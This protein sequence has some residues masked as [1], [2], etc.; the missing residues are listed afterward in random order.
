MKKA[1]VLFT[2]NLIALTSFS[3]DKKI[4]NEEY[5]G[6][7]KNVAVQHFL[8]YKIPASITMAQAILESGSGNS[9]LAQK[10]NNHFGIKCHDWTG[11]K[12]YIDDDQKD[13]CFRVY[14]SP[15]ASYQDHSV[16]LTSKKR[17]A[18][19]FELPKTDYKSWAKGLKDAGYATNPKYPNLLIDLIER[20]HLEDLDKINSLQDAP[21]NEELVAESNNKKS[22]VQ[23]TS[24]LNTALVH[25][26]QVKY[27]VAQK[28]DTYYQIAERFG[29]ALWEL[30]KYNDLD[31]HQDCL[32]E[33]DVVYVQPKRNKGLSDFIVLDKEMTLNQVAQQEAIKVKK[34]M[35]KND[36]QNPNSLLAK[37]TKLKL[38]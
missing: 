37:G 8:I 36:L 12:I 28:G 30:Y 31:A 10:G 27:V 16:F 15:E 23:L 11:E 26:N 20:L 29:M 22:K 13:D 21:K 4:S 24:R 18:N 6:K 35:R 34:I 38:R 2:A 25:Q 14:E 17:Y 5:V 19:L 32:K 1:I 9:I 3:N 7:Y 33:G